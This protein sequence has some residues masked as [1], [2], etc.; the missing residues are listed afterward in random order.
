MR[1]LEGNER[2]CADYSKLYMTIKRKEE[3]GKNDPDMERRGRRS[4]Q[5]RNESKGAKA[6]AWSQANQRMA[7]MRMDK[8]S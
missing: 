4:S 8:L 5:K 3:E 2:N 7:M 1:K 6:S